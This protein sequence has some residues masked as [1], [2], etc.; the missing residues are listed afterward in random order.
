MPR[1]PVPANPTLFLG[2]EVSVWGLRGRSRDAHPAG[3][4]PFRLATRVPRVPGEPGSEQP[5]HHF[6]PQTG[7][8]DR[9][10]ACALGSRAPRAPRPHHPGAGM[11]ALRAPAPP[12][13]HVCA[14]RARGPGGALH[15]AA[16][17]GGRA[18]ALGGTLAGHPERSLGPAGRRRRAGVR[19]RR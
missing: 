5:S 9:A 8:L 18:Q 12:P 15:R 2:H 10:A 11:C 13:S 4:P 19:G 17:G 1:P 3:G 6:Q 7:K 14:A 16:P